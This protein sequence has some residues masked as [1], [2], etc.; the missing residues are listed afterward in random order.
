M[1][2]YR[3]YTSNIIM[4]KATDFSSG[5]IFSKLYKCEAGVCKIYKDG[6]FY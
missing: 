6:R 2:A 4:N 3:K 1:F 5:A